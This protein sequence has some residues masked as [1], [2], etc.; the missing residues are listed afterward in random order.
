MKVTK[1]L[2]DQIKKNK[3]VPN[4]VSACTVKKILKSKN[5]TEYRKKFCNKKEKEVTS[6]TAGAI[7]QHELNMLNNMGDYYI[8]LKQQVEVLTR[9]QF[10]GLGVAVIGFTVLIAMLAW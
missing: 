4:S 7:A 8:S 1:E 5:Y 9:L 3:I 10:I 6:F 2:F